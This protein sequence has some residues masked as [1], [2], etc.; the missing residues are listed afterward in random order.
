MKFNEELFPLLKEGF[1]KINECK[2]DIESNDNRM[3]FKVID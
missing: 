1:K 2:E 3:G